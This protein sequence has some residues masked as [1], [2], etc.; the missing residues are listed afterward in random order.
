MKFLEEQEKEIY[1]FMLK[2]N[3]DF[4]FKEKVDNK[5]VNESSDLSIFEIYALEEILRVGD[6]FYFNN[7]VNYL[8]QK[9]GMKEIT[10]E[11]LV[12]NYGYSP[13]NSILIDNETSIKKTL[14]NLL[15][16]ELIF[17][18]LNKDKFVEIKNRQKK[19]GMCDF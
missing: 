5:Y 8:K 2:Y 19:P 12:D 17:D 7:F 1:D 4:S 3:S 13:F 14:T 6:R 18:T 11:F 16:G 10:G 9:Y 15:F